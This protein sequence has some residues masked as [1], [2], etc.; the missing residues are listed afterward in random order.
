MSFFT[1]KAVAIL[2]ALVAIGPALLN[3]LLLVVATT[4]RG[5][6]FSFAAFGVLVLPWVWVSSTVRLRKLAISCA[7]ALLVFV[8]GATAP[9][10]PRFEGQVG[11]SQVNPPTRFSIFAWL[12]EVDQMTLGSFVMTYFDGALDPTRAKRL[13]GLLPGVYR[14]LPLTGSM[15]G[16]SPSPKSPQTFCVLPYS[17]LNELLPLVVFV[18]GSGGNFVAY[19]GLLQQ[20]A[21]AGRFVIVSPGFGFGNWHE[22]GGVE[23]IAE[24]RAWAERTLPVDPKRVALVA[25]SNG[26]RALTRLV[27]QD[28]KKRWTTIVALSAVV[29]PDLLSDA[30]RGRS[31]LFIHGESDERIPA[32]DALEATIALER[33]GATVAKRFWPAEDHFLWFSKPTEIERA[34]VPWL[35]SALAHVSP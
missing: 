18:H 19:Q 10:I 8:L 21:N 1:R 16:V 9:R 6:L 22:E 20:W 14:G 30:W 32:A 23:T 3:A 2:W 34:V 33:F 12:P 4:W 15:L 31:V 27:A 35:Q 25:L 13:R 17:Q 29:E 7:V 5:T 24:A 26:G 11:L 28:T